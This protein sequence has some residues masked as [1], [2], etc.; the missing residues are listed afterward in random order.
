MTEYTYEWYLKQ[1][2]SQQNKMSVKQM[3]MLALQDLNCGVTSIKH[4]HYL[5]MQFK[6]CNNEEDLKK[7]SVFSQIEEDIRAYHLVV[8][9]NEIMK[10]QV[11]EEKVIS[12][13]YIEAIVSS[14]S[15]PVSD[16]F[17]SSFIQQ[18]TLAL[19]LN[20]KFIDTLKSKK[21][22]E[23]TLLYKWFPFFLQKKELTVIDLRMLRPI[24]VISTRQQRED[25]LFH[26]KLDIKFHK[27]YINDCGLKREEQAFKYKL[28]EALM[29][30]QNIDIRFQC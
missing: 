3:L 6:F 27:K 4:D 23:T 2:N 26:I 1:Q 11:A 13:N 28:T 8:I 10:N 7:S 22:I 14:L 17:D 9:P 19:V 21:T 18:Y 12:K 24:A 15:K 25:E 16:C 20:E 5:K 29:R 30:D